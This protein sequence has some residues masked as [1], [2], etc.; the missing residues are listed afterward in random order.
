[1]PRTLCTT[2][3]RS[4]PVAHLVSPSLG[5]AVHPQ[6]FVLSPP[7]S[8]L[9]FLFKTLLLSLAF[10]HPPLRSAMY[11]L[12]VPFVREPGTHN[13]FLFSPSIFQSSNCT[14][15][16]AEA[17]FACPAVDYFCRPRAV[18]KWRTARGY[19]ALCPQ[20]AHPECQ[21]ITAQNLFHFFS[22]SPPY[23][24]IELPAVFTPMPPPQVHLSVRMEWAGYLSH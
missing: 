4:G 1:M 17:R 3:S 24:K 22:V 16:I 20:R 2:L 23:R 21:I 13:D 11:G 7:P 19:A 6:S 18:G 5:H 9:Y 12:S 14:L 10:L 8:F 15:L